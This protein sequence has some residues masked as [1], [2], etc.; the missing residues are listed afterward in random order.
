MNEFTRKAMLL[1]E[2]L[3]SQSMWLGYYEEG[4]ESFRETEVHAEA[5]RSALLA[6]LEGGEQKWLP[7][8]TAPRGSGEDGPGST[9]HPDYIEPPQIL[10]MTAE[11]PMVGAYDWYYHPGYGAGGNVGESPWRAVGSYE[12]CYEPTHWMPLPATPTE[13]A[14]K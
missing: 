1:A 4:G 6:H 13:E 2:E 9:I 14:S 7:I 3:A 10:L 8:E 11:G 12:Q 5:A